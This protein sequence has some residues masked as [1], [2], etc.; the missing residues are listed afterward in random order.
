MY[1]YVLVEARRG[2]WISVAKDT[3]GCKVST[4]VLGTEL[5]FSS[6]TAKALNL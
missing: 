2:C 4:R 5:G 6:R 1:I 3:A